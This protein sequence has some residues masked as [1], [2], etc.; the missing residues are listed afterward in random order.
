MKLVFDTDIGDDVDDVL[1]LALILSCPELEL[2]GVSTVYGDT[3]TRVKLAKLVLKMWGK[4]DV[5]VAAGCGRPLEAA[6]AP[7]VGISQ[8]SVL[9]ELK[10]SL[11][12]ADPRE[13]HKLLI[14]CVISDPGKVT[15]LTVG[16]MTNLAVALR[17]EPAIVEKAAGFVSMAGVVNQ[18]RAEWN[19]MCDPAAAKECFSSKAGLT[20]VGLDVTTKC[21][22]PEDAIQEMGRG[23]ERGKLLKK[24]IDLWRG[25]K[26]DLP[27]LHDPLAA[28][29]VAD[30][31]LCKTERGA[32][33]VDRHAYTRFQADPSGNVLVCTDVDSDRFIGFYRERVVAGACAS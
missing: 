32:V 21:Q 6:Q 28:G 26:K 7:R 8:A 22:L 5:P 12:P 20:M 11:P 27:T 19:V 18:K 23:N 25:G 15:V 17:E 31:T 29:V 16:A 24:F 9:R 13:G 4:G 10:E 2:V 30:P 14:D 1:A 3:Q 33:S